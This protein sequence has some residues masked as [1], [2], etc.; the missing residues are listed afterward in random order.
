MKQ[1]KNI[2]KTRYRKNYSWLNIVSYLFKDG[3]WH[4]R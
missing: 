4:F 1:R 3:K 2:E